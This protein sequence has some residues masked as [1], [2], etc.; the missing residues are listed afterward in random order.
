MPFIIV[1][2]RNSPDTM[3]ECEQVRADACLFKP[4]ESHEF[5]K[6]ITETILAGDEG[7]GL[8]DLAESETRFGQATTRFHN[9]EILDTLALDNLENLGNAPDFIADLINRFTLESNQILEQMEMAIKTDDAPAF[10]YHA[11]LLV[12]SAG[13]LGAFALYEMS[14]SA[15][16]IDDTIFD[17]KAPGLLEQMKSIYALTSTRFT[18]YLS[19]RENA[20]SRRS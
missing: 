14:L 19:E 6:V 3:R 20:A 13:H 7:S 9:P 1:S 18:E 8:D 11:H 10:R 12:D 17:E 2:E 5:L 16:R 4:I 15:T